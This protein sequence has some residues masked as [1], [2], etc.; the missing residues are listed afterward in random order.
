M[1]G[2]QTLIGVRTPTRIGVRTW[3]LGQQEDATHTILV[4]TS[5]DLR[6]D[7]LILNCIDMMDSLLQKEGVDLKITTYK[8]CRTLTASM[9]SPHFRARF[10]GEERTAVAMTA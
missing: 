8:V 7:Q 4:K 9:A 2:P 10:A 1:L 6:R 3:V 5:N